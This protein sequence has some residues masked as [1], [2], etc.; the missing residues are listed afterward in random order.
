MY[1]QMIIATKK[2][3]TPL[4]VD[5]TLEDTKETISVDAGSTFSSNQAVIFSDRFSMLPAMYCT[6]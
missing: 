6:I 1:T 3:T 5:T 4:M 2:F